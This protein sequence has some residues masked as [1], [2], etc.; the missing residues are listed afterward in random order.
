MIVAMLYYAAF[1]M[2]E[3]LTVIGLAVFHD[4]KSLQQSGIFVCQV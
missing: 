4:G 1:C 3:T 2:V